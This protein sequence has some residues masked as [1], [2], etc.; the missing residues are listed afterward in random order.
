MSFVT[1]R[2]IDELIDKAF[3]SSDLTSGGLLEPDQA[4]RLVEGVIEESV[5]LKELRR[6]VMI[7]DKKQIDKITYAS[8]VLQ[9]PTAVGTVPGTTTKPTTSKV[10][11]D[12][13]EQLGAI[14][15]GY[16]ALE[17]NIEGDN[18]FDTILELTSLKL[19]YELDNLCLNGNTA[20]ASLTYLDTLDGVFKQITTNTVDAGSVTLSD[21][22]LFNTL[23]NLDSKYRMQMP[24][25]RF[26]VNPQAYLDYVKALADK[27][28]DSAFTNYLVKGGVPS[29]QGIPVI[30][31]PAVT[32][33]NIGTGTLTVNGS[34]GLLCNPANIVMGIHRDI[35]YE[36]QRQ[37]RKRIIEVTISMRL[38]FKLE[39][40]DATVEINNILHST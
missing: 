8:D 24:K 19:A 26:Y 39:Q 9:V 36:F 38:D 28:V 11:L 40:E 29:F 33:E 35:T 4:T 12:S 25:L 30:Q 1:P 34:K 18:L 15:L 5:I 16:D 6:E 27:N 17:D 22:I 21:T 10:T 14:D 37:P 20:G 32:T 31:V 23:K 2:T 3:T 7:S 13:V